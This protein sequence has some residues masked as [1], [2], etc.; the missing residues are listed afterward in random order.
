MNKT[1]KN[2]VTALVLLLAVVMLLSLAACGKEEAP[3][4]TQAPAAPVAT[5]APAAQTAAPTE[6]PAAQ[7]SAQPEAEEGVFVSASKGFRFEY[8]PNYIAVANPADN[9]MIYPT[10]DVELPFC[11]VSLISGSSAV[12]YLK[13]MSAAAQEELGDAIKSQPGEPADAGVEGRQIYFISF[14]YDS[15]EAEGTVVCSYYAED[16]PG[17]DIVVYNATALEGDTAVADGIVKTAIDTFA[18]D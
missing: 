5:E 16:L 9:A 1:V 17:G 8:A 13:E 3:A 4:A 12:D 10:G 18:M 11:S 7:P 2:I 6:E 14:S 15:F